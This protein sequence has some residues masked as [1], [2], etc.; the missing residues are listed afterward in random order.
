MEQT[1]E[2]CYWEIG[3]PTYYPLPVDG[4]THADYR[5]CALSFKDDNN[6]PL[7][8]KNETCGRWERGPCEPS[9]AVTE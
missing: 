1:C 3:V 9:R 2:T 7:V 6:P 8:C 4:A 5:Q